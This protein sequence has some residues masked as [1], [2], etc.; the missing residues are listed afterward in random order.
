MPHNLSARGRSPLTGSMYSRRLAEPF[1]A[2]ILAFAGAILIGT[3]FLSAPACQN[4]P[5]PLIDVVFIAVS[6]ASVTGLSPL[7][8]FTVFNRGGQIVILLLMQLG[9]IGII[10]YATLIISFRRRISLL[11]HLAVEQSVFHQPGRPLGSYIRRIVTMVLALEL[12]GFLLLLRS[13][14]LPPFDALFLSVSAFCNA[15]FSPYADSAES[16]GPASQFVLMGLIISGGLGFFALDDCRQWLASRLPGGEGPKTLSFFTRVVFSTSLA[17]ILGGAAAILC[18]G[19]FNPAF[20]DLS[21]WKRI[22]DALFQSVTA[23]TAGFASVPQPQFS[24]ASLLFTILLMLIGGAPGS[25]SGGIKCSTFRVL[26]GN[27]ISNFKGS[28]QTVV[29]GRAMD[30][31]T[32]HKSLVLFYNASLLIFIMSLAILLFE[33]GAEP[34]RDGAAYFAILFEVVSAFCTAGLSLDMTAAFSGASKMILCA[35]MFI[36]KLGPLWLLGA[37]RQF[38][39]KKAWR[40]AEDSLPV[41]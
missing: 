31:A 20:A 21:F 25:C 22:L 9:G 37:I 28:D 29:A 34:Y 4:E 27:L 15:G 8:P 32:V 23:R 26:L 7:D 14:R 35:A 10:T 17:L 39:E 38:Q 40:Y 5:V 12:A 13:G 33:R 6:A 16:L 19:F 24:Q 30:R 18:I 2:P 1:L 41:G 11:E 36:G 3:L